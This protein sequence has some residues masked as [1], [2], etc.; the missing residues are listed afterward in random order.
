MYDHEMKIERLQPNRHQRDH[1]QCG[2]PELDEYLSKRAGQDQKRKLAVTYV[3]A[4]KDSEHVVGYYTLSAYSVNISSC[5]DN[6]KRRLPKYPSIPGVLIGRLA[7]DTSYRGYGWGEALLMSALSK[8]FRYSQSIGALAVF[9]H[10]KDDKAKGF[11]QNYDFYELQ[12]DPY[13]LFLPMKTIK[14]LLEP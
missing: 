14:K 6:L 5:P 13:H 11:Y 12:D 1:F 10:A 7:V 3:L 2:Y 9:V 8:C 4:Q